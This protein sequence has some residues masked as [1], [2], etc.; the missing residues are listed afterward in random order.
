MHEQECVLGENEGIVK[1]AQPEM[2][3]RGVLWRVILF[4]FKESEPEARPDAHDQSHCS[5]IQFVVMCFLFLTKRERERGSE[6][7][8][9]C[10][11]FVITVCFLAFPST[12]TS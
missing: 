11:L 2:R 9:G 5:S 12:R 3:E 1:S 10:C 6:R 8:G 4:V 7:G